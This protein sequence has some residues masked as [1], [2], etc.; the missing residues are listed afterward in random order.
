MGNLPFFPPLEQRRKLDQFPLEAVGE[1]EPGGGAGVLLLRTA[2]E[3]H[4][5][6]A[7]HPQ[8]VLDGDE[9]LEG[10][11]VDAAARPLPKTSDGGNVAC[12]CKRRKR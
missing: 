4:R 3:M 8:Q 7:H 12:Q 1:G 10:V 9:V 11:L 2:L 5:P 6:A